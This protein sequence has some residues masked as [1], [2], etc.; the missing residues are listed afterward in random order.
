MIAADGG[1]A[2]TAVPL[3]GSATYAN[4]AAIATLVPP[5]G[6]LLVHTNGVYGDRLNEICA[7]NA[8]PH[9]V[10]RTPP[11]TPATE[12]QFDDALRAT[13]E[14]VRSLWRRA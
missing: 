4:E 14:H 6:K 3:P 9:A 11:F 12:A 5:G 8:T 2:Y 1:G 10:L 13:V 7:A